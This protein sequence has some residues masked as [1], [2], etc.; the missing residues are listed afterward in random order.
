MSQ[1]PDYGNPVVL[2]VGSFSETHRLGV[3]R[4]VLKLESAQVAMSGLRFDN[5]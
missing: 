5:Q 2:G 3:K 4:H 1:M